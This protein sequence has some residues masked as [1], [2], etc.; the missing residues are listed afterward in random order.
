MLKTITKA[1][2]L[3]GFALTVYGFSVDGFGPFQSFAL[4]VFF[5]W[6]YIYAAD[7]IKI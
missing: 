7:Q 3:A 5:V 2:A 4:V 1:A 6:A